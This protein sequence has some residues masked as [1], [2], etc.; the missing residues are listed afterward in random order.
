[1]AIVK[2]PITQEKIDFAIADYVR[3]IFNSFAGDG[4]FS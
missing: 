1:M 4:S 2:P 3:D